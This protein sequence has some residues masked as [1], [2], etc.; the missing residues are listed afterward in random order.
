VKKLMLLIVSLTALLGG[1][2][3]AQDITGNWQGTL[4]TAAG[5]EL[6]IIL[7][8]TKD[9]GRLR[10]AVYSIDQGAQPFK[11]SSVVLDGGNF[12]SSFDVIGLSYEAKLSVDGKSMSGTWTQGPNA[13]PL[14]L[15]LP[16]KAAAWEIPAP[17]QPPKLMAADADPSFDVATIKPNNSG[18]TSMQGLTISGRNFATRASSLQDLIGFAYEV[19]AKQIT[20]GPDWMDKDRYDIA[21]VPDKEGA[22]N[23]QQVRSMIRKLLADRFKLTFHKETRELSAFVLT[24]EKDGPKLTPTQLNGPL[25]GLGLAP[26][27]GGVNLRVMNGRMVDFT[28]FLQQLVLDRPVVDQTGLA[29]KFDFTV[30]FS[31][32]DSQFNGHPPPFAKTAEG[33]EPAPSLFEAL[34]EQLGLKLEAKKTQVD[35]I[36]IDHVE[37][38]SAN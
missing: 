6:R 31:P 37:K 32:D 23:P 17:P 3:R 8:I 11:A 34:H 2:L 38:P 19:Q 15:V 12:K 29:A 1:A 25:P 4:T 35:V 22:P 21:A 10:A 24:V 20:G 28:G 36:A 5:K 26:G 14:N 16:P 27:K 13:L 7:Q 9:D 18:A 33:V 30:T